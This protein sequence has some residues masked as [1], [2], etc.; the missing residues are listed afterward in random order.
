MAYFHRREDPGKTPVRLFHQPVDLYAVDDEEELPIT[1]DEENRRS[2]INHYR[3]LASMGDFFGVILGAVVILV[4]IALLISLV[5]WV[6]NDMSLHPA[7]ASVV[8]KG[9]GSRGGDH[10][11]T[12]RPSGR[13]LHD[14]PPA[15][16]HSP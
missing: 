9:G 3:F 1:E 5:H 6:R 14:V 4:L 8:N 11:G 15:Q 2:R 12:V 16:R 10:L 13:S 7:A